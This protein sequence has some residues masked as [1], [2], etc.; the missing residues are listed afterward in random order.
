[1]KDYGLAFI[2]AEEKK[3]ARIRA[4][5]DKNL[6]KNRAI[7]KADDLTRYVAQILKIP[8]SMK[9]QTAAIVDPDG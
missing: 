5:L 6:V 4:Y 7:A 3:D 2:Y 9:N 1:M 8:D